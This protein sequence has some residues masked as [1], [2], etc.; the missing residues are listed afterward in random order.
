MT[1]RK[2]NAFRDAGKGGSRGAYC[3][4]S[5]WKGITNL[6]ALG[7]GR[8]RGGTEARNTDVAAISEGSK[9][10]QGCGRD[11]RGGVWRSGHGTRAR[12]RGPRGTGVVGE[13]SGRGFAQ[14]QDRQARCADSQRG[15]VPRGSAERS[16]AEASL[17]RSKNDVPN[18]RAAHRRSN[19]THQL[20]ARLDAWPGDPR[21]SRG[22]REFPYEGAPRR[23]RGARLHRTSTAEHRTADRRDSRSRSGAQGARR[24]RCASPEALHGPWSRSGHS[25]SLCR[26][27]RRRGSLLQRTP[28]RV[29]SGPRSGREAKLRETASSGDHE[30][31]RVGSATRTDSSRV[32]RAPGE[33]PAADDALGSRDRTTPRQIRRHGCACAQAGRNPVRTVARRNQLSARPVGRN[34]V[35]V[36]GLAQSKALGCCCTRNGCP[37]VVIAE[38]SERAVRPRRTDSDPPT[39]FNLCDFDRGYSIETARYVR[40]GDCR[41]RRRIAHSPRPTCVLTWAPL[42]TR[43]V[44]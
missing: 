16:R 29:V 33:N 25:G 11:V 15:F 8:H 23:K 21:A 37:E 43:R 44:F 14:P 22:D 38:T 40:R 27:N 26:G 24:S 41:R 5:G 12:T 32:G 6:R 13:K 30:S 18:A 17:A 10:V 36:T 4:R 42:H 19:A 20:R 28:A 9:Q 2:I 7:G 39:D 3:D 1:S 35:A 34:A 31:G